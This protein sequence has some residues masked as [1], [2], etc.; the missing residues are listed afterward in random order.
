MTEIWNFGEF[1]SG[2]G[3]AECEWMS[4]LKYSRQQKQN[5]LKKKIVFINR[6]EQNKK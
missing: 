4:N 5:L 6:A 1:L 3:R 2:A